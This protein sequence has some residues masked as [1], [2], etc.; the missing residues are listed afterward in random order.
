MPKRI[1]T[2]TECPECEAKRGEWCT[3]LTAGE[4]HL[5]RVLAW[6]AGRLQAKPDVV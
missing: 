5:G 4:L 1:V 6:Y 2:V 3:G